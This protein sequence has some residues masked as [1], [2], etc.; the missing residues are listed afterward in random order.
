MDLNFYIGRYGCLSL[1]AKFKGFRFET[2]SLELGIKQFFAKAGISKKQPVGADLRARQKVGIQLLNWTLEGSA[3]EKVVPPILD[4]ILR[5]SGSVFVGS[6]M[7]GTSKDYPNGTPN[8][9]YLAHR[10]VITIGFNTAY[11]AK[12][13]EK[14]W[15]PG[16]VSQQ[17]GDTGNKYIEKHLIADGEDL[18]KLYADFFK[19]E[20]EQ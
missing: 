1:M 18:V 2:K 5:G 10:D 8:R 6:K 16:P 15:N 3:H 20:V 14:E 19:K 11:A 9:S 17:S 4:G 13:H 7:V 12:L